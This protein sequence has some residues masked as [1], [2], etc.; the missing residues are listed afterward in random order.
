[1]VLWQY[2]L[3][4]MQAL[5]QL[6][7]NCTLDP[8]LACQNWAEVHAETPEDAEARYEE[9][10][11][12]VA[13]EALWRKH[14]EPGKYT[15]MV[16]VRN[17]LDIT[18]IAGA[19]SGFSILVDNGTCNKRNLTGKTRLRVKALG[20]CDSGRAYTMWQMHPDLIGDAVQNVTGD[21][22]VQDRP[23]SI[24]VAWNL[25]RI[26]PRAWSTWS[27]ARA[28]SLRWEA[29]HSLKGIR[30]EEESDE[31]RISAE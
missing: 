16:L 29:M 12:Q 8:R 25:R 5:T 14:N 10:A 28:M 19:E 13:E 24:H 6:P 21:E 11:H 30:L 15:D 3:T 4:A 9:I 23:N 18:F 31:P 1:M 27:H 20:G 2:L 17:A 7:G 22:L 26:R